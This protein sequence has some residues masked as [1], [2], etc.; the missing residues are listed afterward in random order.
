MKKRTYIQP[1]SE[2]EPFAPLIL[3]EF[4]GSGDVKPGGGDDSDDDSRVNA[5]E[6]ETWGTLW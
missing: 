4:T 2:Q 1:M 3:Q 6:E 5:H